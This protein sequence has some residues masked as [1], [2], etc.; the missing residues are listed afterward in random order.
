MTIPASVFYQLVEDIRFR[1]Y[2]GLSVGEEEIQKAGREMMGKADLDKKNF[3]ITIGSIIK[4]FRDRYRQATRTGF[5]DSVA[6]LDLIMLTKELD[7]YLVSTDE[8]VIKWG[9]TFGVKEITAPVFGEKMK[10]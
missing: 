8:G 9:R 5:L 3:Q 1:S 7:G 2:R 4:T 10:R 6:D